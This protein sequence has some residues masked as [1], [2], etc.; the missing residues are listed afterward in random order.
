MMS[1]QDLEKFK[2]AASRKFCPFING[3]CK[4]FGCMFFLS[5]YQCAITRIAINLDMLREGVP[6]VRVFRDEEEVKNIKEELR[7]LRERVQRIEADHAVFGGV[8]G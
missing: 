2:E 1:E 8:K 3:K 7:N 6:V 5:N 4:Q